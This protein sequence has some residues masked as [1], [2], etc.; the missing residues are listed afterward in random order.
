MA[1]TKPGSGGSP[2]SQRIT[3]RALPTSV[4][5]S[6]PGPASSTSAAR[7]SRSRRIRGSRSPART[8][9]TTP[10][11]R[12]TRVAGM[13]WAADERRYSATSSRSSAFLKEFATGFPFVQTINRAAMRP[14]RLL[15]SRFH[16]M[17]TREPPASRGVMRALT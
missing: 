15:G 13:M 7:P 17:W 10:T 16:S 3:R 1:Y 9:R 2:P 8:E 11:A 5:G 6:S 12:M 14:L 4:R